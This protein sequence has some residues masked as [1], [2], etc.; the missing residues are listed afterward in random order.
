MNSL[1]DP[2]IIRKLYEASE[3]GVEIDLI[4]RGV[5]R[6]IPGKKRL[7]ENIRVHSIIGK[8]L[9]HSRCYY[10]HHAGE[11]LYYIGSADWMHRNLDASVEVLAPIQDAP[12]KKYLEF[13]L[14]LHMSASTHGCI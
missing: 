6:L 5:C 7:S 2:G 14:D 11:E 1:E 9:E 3:A 10:F 4:V 12:V 8:Y 13:I